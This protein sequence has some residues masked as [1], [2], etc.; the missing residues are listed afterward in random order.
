M[1][2]E[3]PGALRRLTDRLTRSSADLDSDALIQKS[4]DTGCL[5]IGSVP[6]RSRATVVGE[7]RSVTLRPREEV[8]ALVVEITDGSGT[9]H[10]V[11]LGRR[12]IPGIAPGVVLR[13]TGRVT[14]QRRARTMFNPSYEIVPQGGQ[15][16]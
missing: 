9:L 14:A 1:V 8:P 15:H 4:S 13:A 6:L 2:Q 10:L 11:W 16:G 12:T 3:R 5:P 7:V